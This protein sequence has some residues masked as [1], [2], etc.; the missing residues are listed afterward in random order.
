MP[1]DETKLLTF[2]KSNITTPVAK[3]H[4]L[5]SELE[6]VL[7]DTKNLVEP[8][9]AKKVIPF[10]LWQNV[11]NEFGFFGSQKDGKR[12]REAT[13]KYSRGRKVFVDLGYNISHE[14][15]EPHPAIVFVNA[16][17][18]LTHQRRNK[19]DPPVCLV[20]NRFRFLLCP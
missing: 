16:G 11:W 15:S 2:Q 6:N 18:H 17:I 4:Y 9:T 14:K 5:K 19:I 13:K 1:I 10:I 3:H 12:R 20:S 7:L 8:H